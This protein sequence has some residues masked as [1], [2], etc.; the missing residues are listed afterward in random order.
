MTLEVV[1]N[2]AHA[3]TLLRVT[4][5][6]M[7]S[8]FPQSGQVFPQFWVVRDVR[9]KTSLRLNNDYFETISSIHTS[10]SHYVYLKTSS[11]QCQGYFKKCFMN[12]S[13]PNNNNDIFPIQ[14]TNTAVKC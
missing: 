7:K 8:L 12:I 10:R 2:I 14:Y 4:D 11:R 6:Q 1:W 5:A 9:L 13:R 3:S